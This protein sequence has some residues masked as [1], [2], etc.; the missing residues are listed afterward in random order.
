MDQLTQSDFLQK[1]ATYLAK[2][3]SSIVLTNG[4]TFCT[5]FEKLSKIWE[6]NPRLADPTQVGN[7]IQG[8]K[9]NDNGIHLSEYKPI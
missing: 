4:T 5:D 8:S 9:L 6:L 3:M 1:E 2:D 7:P